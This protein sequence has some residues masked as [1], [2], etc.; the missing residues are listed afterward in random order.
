M[1]GNKDIEVEQQKRETEYS[2]LIDWHTR[3]IKKHQD[4][5]KDLKQRLAKKQN[6]KIVRK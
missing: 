1:N 6:A 5:I 2:V 4:R 3:Q